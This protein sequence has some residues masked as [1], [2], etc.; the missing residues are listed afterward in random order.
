[1]RVRQSCCVSAGREIRSYGGTGMST[2]EYSEIPIA[3]DSGLIN[4]GSSISIKLQRREVV[5]GNG[6]S[7]IMLPRA[8]SQDQALK[9]VGRKGRRVGFKRM[10]FCSP[11]SG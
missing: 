5:G 9:V 6:R 10:A 2:G 8:D 4:Y 11:A 7:G 1:M 3:G